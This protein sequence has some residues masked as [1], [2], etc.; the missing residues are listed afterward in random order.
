MHNQRGYTL[1]ELL[2][3]TVIIGTLLTAVSLFAA[4]ASEARI[5]NQSIAEV[6]QQGTFALEYIS[7]AV[8]NATSITSPAAASTDAQLTLVVPTGSLSPTIFNLASNQL[9]V[10]EGAATAIPLTGG[11]VQV[12]NF[13]V[14]N[15]TRAGTLGIVQI[16]LTL[17]RVNANGRNQYDYQ[18]TFTTSAMVRP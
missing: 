14:K 10:K 17:S 2:L 12:T 16:S 5:K 15:L 13:T 4:T 18:K 7:Q 11:K 6:D 9:Q 3:Y 1:I 8:R